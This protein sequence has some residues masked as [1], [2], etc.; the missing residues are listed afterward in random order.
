MIIN[1]KIINITI[2]LNILAFLSI[3][4]NKNLLIKTSYIVV[5]K[6]SYKRKYIGRKENSE[7]L[8]INS[9]VI[10][11]VIIDRNKFI[12]IYSQYLI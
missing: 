6:N 12:L 11:I 10:R 1:Y 9:Q 8:A 4:F 3:L 2:K 7:H 5:D